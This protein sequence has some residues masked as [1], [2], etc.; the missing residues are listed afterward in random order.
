MIATLDRELHRVVALSIALLPGK[1]SVARFRR[2]LVLLSGRCLEFGRR[3][4][5]RF[6]ALADGSTL[7]G[8][9]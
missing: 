5:L 6:S 7:S 3:S 4:Q 1:R 8:A 2:F 9:G